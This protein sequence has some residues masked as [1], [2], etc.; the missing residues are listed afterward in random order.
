MEIVNMMDQLGPEKVFHVY[1]PETKM[2][3]VVVVDTT[4]DQTAGGGTRMMPDIS[5]REIFGLARAMTYKFSI[6]GLPIGGAKAGIWADPGMTGT[7]RIALMEAFGRGVKPL[8]DSG[9]VLGAD[10]GTSGTDVE[11]IYRGAN[12]PS[13]SEGLAFEMLDGDPLENHATGFG[14]V[15]AA[16]AACQ[17]AGIE[18]SN[19][20]AAIEGFGKVGGGVARY[21]AES[22]VKVTAVSTLYGTRY[23]PDGL[24]VG[25]LLELRKEAGDKVVEV[26]QKGKLLQKEDIFSLPVDILIPGARPYVITKDNVNQI[27]ARVIS[28]S[29]NIPITD[30]AEEVLFKQGTIVVPDF[31]SNAGGIIVALIDTMKGSADDVF[32][33]LR[34]AIPKVTLDT[35]AGSEQA[36]VNPRK[37]AISVAEKTVLNSRKNNV[38]QSFEEILVKVKETLGL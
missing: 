14:V 27:K 20:S 10:I 24:D 9:I 22:G 1:D 35:L 37:Y 2:K 7:E 3:G 16:K 28:S 17:K 13:L 6:F 11:T 32:N 15:E 4:F 30:E 18:L 25:Q 26:Y 33:T 8:L 23:D 31:I 29:A 34:I 36:N 5:A 21:F 19:A 12:S 38:K